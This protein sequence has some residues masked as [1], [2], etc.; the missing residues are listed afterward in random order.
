MITLSIDLET[1]SS[2]DLKKCGVYAYTEAPDFEILLFGYASN[3]EPVKVID[4]T[5]G[6]RLPIHLQDA[7]LNPNIVKTAFNANFE[8]VCLSKYFEFRLNQCQMDFIPP[9]NWRCTQVHALTLGL[10]MRLEDVAKA[11]K[12]QQQKDAAGKALIRY[13]SVPCKPSKTNGQRTRNL[14]EH[15]PEKWEQFKEYC[16]QDVVVERTIREK[17]L[18]HPISAFE[19]KLWNLDQAIND[20]GVLIDLDLVK[21]AIACDTA[22]Q[23]R[24]TEE[25]IKLTGLDNPKSVSQLKAWLLET[26]GL[27][28]ESLNKES[29]P[30]LLKQ[31][32]S[33]TVKRVLELRQEMSRTSVKKYEAMDRAHCMD[34]RIRGTM[35]FYGANRTGRW[36]IA[37]GSLVRVRT[38]ESVICDKPIERVLIT[39]K[40]WD[41]STW[42]NH[43]GVVFSGE[44]DVIEWDGITA[45]PEHTVWVGP[46][47]K[48]ALSDARKHERKLW[49]G[50][51]VRDI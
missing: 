1:Y 34:N 28:V 43:N 37:E 50:D 21:N 5:G 3:D 24:R 27:E 2:V 7:I 18:R 46:N 12:L 11:L 14:P 9:T 19:Q 51:N 16:R 45:T 44:K 25:A 29:V 17:L 40:V 47:E 42:V 41:G 48:M 26:D 39:D 8:R 30:E 38:K 49:C 20:R 23:Q 32:E 22:Y 4:L 13:F 33:A 10:P 31:T 36:C 15:A 6:K 35:Q